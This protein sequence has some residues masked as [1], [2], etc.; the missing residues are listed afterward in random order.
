[1][2]KSIIL[3]TIFIFFAGLF[4]ITNASAMLI[5]PE[6]HY[7]VGNETYRMNSNM[8]FSTITMG[9]NTISFDGIVFEVFS[10]NPIYINFSYF[11][12]DVNNA[13]DNVIILRFTT[14]TNSGLVWF[15]ISGMK[16]STSYN[17]ERDGVVIDNPTS[18]GSGSISFYNNL[19][20]EH[21]IIIVSGAAAE[22]NPSAYDPHNFTYIRENLISWSLQGYENALGFLFFPLV[23]TGIIGYVYIK[24]Q[25]VVI[26]G[27]A[28][29]II[30]AAF[31]NTLINVD[32][33]VTVM[34]IIFALAI[35]ALFL[36]WFSKR[37]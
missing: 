25:S 12:G 31:G 28:I 1:M 10:S 26:L 9:S 23:F 18:D 3:I 35:T 29:L 15:N 27:V 8:S 36:Y 22:Y 13:G 2:N 6:N 20:S 14:F 19:W 33:W 30:F 21:E 4:I 32:A 34:Q 5:T 24:N 7:V 37:R 16:T 17:V 11:I